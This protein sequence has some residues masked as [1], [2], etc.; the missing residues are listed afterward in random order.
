M[1]INA[2]VCWFSINT[3][4][5]GVFTASSVRLSWIRFGLNVDAGTNLIIREELCNRGME[6]EYII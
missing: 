2:V 5:K 6:Q 3:G 1:Y 4:L